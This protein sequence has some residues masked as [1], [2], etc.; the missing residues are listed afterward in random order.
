MVTTTERVQSGVRIE[1][2]ILKVLKALA[3]YYD[4]SLGDLVEV[5]LLASFEGAIPFSK[6]TLKRIADLKRIYDLD[7]DAKAASSVLYVAAAGR[8]AVSGAG[9]RPRRG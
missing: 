3:E 8:R 1:R 4:V 5:I 6:G 2:R 7:L 9:R